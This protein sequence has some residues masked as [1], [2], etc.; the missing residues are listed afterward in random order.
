MR[1]QRD[2][3][4]LSFISDRIEWQSD[5]RSSSSHYH[6]LLQ[7]LENRMQEAPSLAPTHLAA[8]LDLLAEKIHRRSLVIIF[9]DLME[10]SQETDHLFNALQHLRFN[11]HEV[12]LFHI[13]D[14]EKEGEFHFQN[15][16]YLF[17][18]PES[19]EQMKVM[20][21]EVRDAYLSAQSEYRKTLRDKAAQFKIDWIEV[22]ANDDFNQVLLQFLIKR[23]KM[24]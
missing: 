16:P 22:D 10:S 14:K 7:Q 21:A 18:D 19:G 15:R 20:P 13:Q 6:M 11:K 17:V 4:S 12:I 3:F 8:S 23:S 24:N 2:A 9:S 1:R 5:V